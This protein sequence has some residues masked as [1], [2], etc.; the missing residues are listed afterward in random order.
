MSATTVLVRLAGE[1]YS[2]SNRTRRRFQ[3]VLVANLGDALADHGEAVRVRN[4]WG[5]LIVTVRRAGA[6]EGNGKEAAAQTV[7]PRARD[8]VARVSRVFGLSSCSIIDAVVPAELESIVRTGRDLYRDAVRGRTYRISSRRSGRH[9][10]ASRDID[11]ELGRA[12]NPYG[13]VDL[14]NPDVTVSVE[15]RDDRAYLFLHR[16]RGAQGLPLGI[17]GRAVCLLSGGF[18]SA[19]AAWLTLKRGATLDYVL[20]NLAGPAFEH[21]VLRVASVLARRWSYGDQPRIHI[22]EFA[23]IVDALRTSVSPRYWQVVLKRLM[24]RAAGRVAADVGASAI[25]TGESLGQVSSQTLGNLG[26][27]EAVAKLPVLRPLVGFDKQEIIAMAQRIGTSALSARVKEYCAILEHWPVTA[28]RADIVR[29]E[30]DSLDLH[31]L[32]LALEQRRVLKLRSLSDADLRRSYVWVDQV[33]DSARII[34]CRPRA[35]D[36]GWR[37]RDALRIVPTA[38]ARQVADLDRAVTYLLFCD[39][40]MHSGR[41]ADLMQTLGFE[42]YALTGGTWT[43]RRLFV[44]EETS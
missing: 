37:C 20:C 23:Q 16:E 29:Q 14:T 35:Q 40:G 2:K 41:F 26:S 38:F 19:V 6:G 3:R 36:D 9:S 39:R 10:F 32:G 21:S 18:D 7:D 22:V 31:A 4:L 8:I 17:Q 12:L 25:V 27:I 34:D 30:E 24:Y 43:L 33:P 11:V 44:G 42:A 13:T 15:A 28:S 1:V 5:R